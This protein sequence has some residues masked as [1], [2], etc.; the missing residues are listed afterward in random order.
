MSELNNQECGL[1]ALLT[2]QISRP[3]HI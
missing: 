3:I 1:K 2:C